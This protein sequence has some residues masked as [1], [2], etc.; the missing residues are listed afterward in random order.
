[1]TAMWATRLLVAAV[2]WIPVIIGRDAVVRAAGLVDLAGAPNPYFVPSHALLLYIW[3]PLVATSAGVALMTPGLIMTLSSRRDGTAVWIMRAFLITIPTVSIA[4]SLFQAVL[5][6]PVTGDLFVAL[7]AG[8]SALAALVNWRQLKAGAQPGDTNG[9]ML[10]MAVPAVLLAA[11]APKFLW[12]SFNGDGAHA[13]WTARLATRQFLPFWDPAAGGV[14]AFPGLATMLFAYPASWFVR[15]FGDIEFAVRA[16]YLLVIS[17]THAAIVATAGHGRRIAGRHVQVLVWLALV[18]YTIVQAYSSTYDPY[19][20]DLSMPGLPDT[21]QV[22]TFLAF[23]HAYLSRQWRWAAAALVLTLLSSPSGLMM[24]VFWLGAIAYFGGRSEWKAA[25]RDALL[26]GGVLLAMTL[27]PTAFRWLGLPQPGRE[28]DLLGLLVRFAFLQFTDWHRLL[29]VVVPAGVF[30]FVAL[31]TWDRLDA[32]GRA[33]FGVSGLIFVVFFVQAHVMLHQFVPATLLPLAA[34]WRTSGPLWSHRRIVAAGALAVAAIVVSLPTNAAPVLA[35]RTIG[36]AVLDEGSDGR[37]LSPRAF[38]RRSLLNSLFPKDYE[39]GVPG[40]TYGGSS[41]AWAY[42]ARK[43]GETSADVN[44]VLVAA[45]GSPPAGLRLHA[46]NR[47]GSLY[48]RSDD[49]WQRHRAMRPPTPAGSLLYRTPRGILFR[50][51]PLEDEGPWI[52]DVRQ[53]LQRLGIDVNRLV[54]RRRGTD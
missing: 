18:A 11:L 30:P 43:R 36:T 39:P 45:D 37:D 47:A 46:T 42:Y 12:E 50:S 34:G 32:V 15:L 5:R 14:A 35:A 6:V 41:L 13:F 27:A 4:A 49:V 48:V 31:L 21:L 53:W 22:F 44:Y 38:Q 17:A 26:L 3:V 9:W 40:E 24:T 19:A 2:F 20:A 25:R 10:H 51:V 16:P 7:L 23:I 29:W 54:Q 28:H 8:V 33:L 52:L 1:M